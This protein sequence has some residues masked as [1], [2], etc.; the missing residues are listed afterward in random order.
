MKKSSSATD[1][2]FIFNSPSPNYPN[3]EEY[4]KDLAR[5]QKEHLDSLRQNQF[6]KPC[7]HDSCPECV[8]TGIKKTGGPCM[9]SLYCDC[10]KCTPM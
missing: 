3:R 4:E 7:A 10:P 1:I 9:H 8:G 5:R 2:H 6:W